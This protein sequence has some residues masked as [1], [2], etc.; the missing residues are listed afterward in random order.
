MVRSAPPKSGTRP[1]GSP[2]PGPFDFSTQQLDTAPQ[3]GRE[4]GRQHD[5]RRTRAR[6]HRAE[7]NPQTLRGGTRHRA[8]SSGR[9][10]IADLV[11]NDDSDSHFKEQNKI[12]TLLSE[13]RSAIRNM[14]KFTIIMVVILL[15]LTSGCDAANHDNS[16]N[17]TNRTLATATPLIA[18][19]AVTYAAVRR[20][21]LR[22]A[23]EKD[24]GSK[25]GRAEKDEENNER[26]TRKEEGEIIEDQ[27][28]EDL[29]E[30]S[31]TIGLRIITQNIRGGLKARSQ[32]I[33]EY[34]KSKEI[35][36][37]VLTET[38]T[39]VDTTEEED[40]LSAIFPEAG[41]IEHNGFRRSDVI[42]DV[43]RAQGGIVVLFSDRIN[44]YVK[45]TSRLEDGRTIEIVIHLPKRKIKLFAVYAPPGA[46]SAPPS[47][48]PTR[49]A[50]GK[51]RA[52]AATAATELAPAPAVGADSNAAAAAALLGEK[53]QNVDSL[54]EWPIF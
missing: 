51:T 43:M 9:A 42:N 25:T 39:L 30:N 8:V 5:A 38:K 24:Y 3:A 33:R 27:S 37:F 35:D 19:A 47:S 46:S 2:K 20:Q 1:P 32:Q 54:N 18:A 31:H 52:A 44:K 28:K 11:A 45:S 22:R 21:P 26:S 16:T 41:R 12:K 49:Q 48:S 14:S 10:K 53:M 34:A 40:K 17:I 15:C 6:V 13:M 7:R 50:S 36:I 23:R 4:G 29:E